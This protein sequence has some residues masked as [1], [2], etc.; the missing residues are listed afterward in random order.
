MGNAIK[1]EFDRFQQN[2]NQQNQKAWDKTNRDFFARNKGNSLGRNTN[3]VFDYS[4]NGLGG[5]NFGRHQLGL[6]SPYDSSNYGNFYSNQGQQGGQGLPQAVQ[7]IAPVIAPG[8][9]GAG[10]TQFGGQGW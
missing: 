6:Q 2:N 4:S 7:E 1:Q 8:A 9:Y 10:R 3:A 5:D